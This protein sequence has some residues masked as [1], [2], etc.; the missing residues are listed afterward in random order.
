MRPLC[1]RR[2]KLMAQASAE[3]VGRRATSYRRASI[4]RLRP[5]TLRSLHSRL[6]SIAPRRDRP[7]KRCDCSSDP[8]DQGHNSTMQP[9]A[10]LQRSLRRLQL[11]TKMVN[12]GFYKGTGSGSMGRHTKHGG[13][14]IERQK[15]RTFCCPPDLSDF[16]VSA[17]PVEIEGRQLT[18]C[19]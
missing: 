9:T 5:I 1:D 4:I 2:K 8:I 14:I 11:T 7:A 12:K 13:Y 3:P 19:S 15:V 16:K 10:A 18:W 17:A 6:Q